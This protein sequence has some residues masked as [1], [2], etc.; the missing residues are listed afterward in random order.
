VNIS[1][2][3]SDVKKKKRKKYSAAP[4]A[5]NRSIGMKNNRKKPAILRFRYWGLL[6]ALIFLGCKGK[7]PYEGRSVSEL[8][9]ML[10]DPD[11]K[12]QAQGAFGLSLKGAEAE[13]ATPALIKATASSDALVRQQAC[14][15]LGKI[16]PVA[17]EATPALTTALADPEWV[18]RRQAAMALG[19]IGPLAAVEAPLEKCRHDPN[20]QVR[21]SAADALALLRKGQVPGKK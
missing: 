9:R 16:G 14:I 18:V 4:F 10:A 13:P 19:Q 11:P 21:K 17:K 6:P 7:P 1:G 15:A 5:R 3:Q 2:T 12:V 20:I 8:Q